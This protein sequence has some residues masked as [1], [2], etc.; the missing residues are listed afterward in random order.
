MFKYIFALASFVAAAGAMPDACLAPEPELPDTVVDIAVSD[1]DFSLLVQALTE[2]ELVDDL[3]GDGPFTVF[4][5]T[6]AAFAALLADLGITAEELLARDDLADILLY[7][8][9]PGEVDSAAAIAA[10]GT[11][12]GTLNG[13]TVDVSL[14]NGDLFI[15]QAQVINT[16]LKAKN[17][18]VHVIDAVLLPD[19]P[20]PATVVDV[21]LQ[22]PD[23]SI[24]YAALV[25]T[26]LDQTLRQSGPYTLFAPTNAAFNDA[27]VALGI[28]LGDLLTDP[29]LADILLYHVL[30]GEVDSSAA[31]AA[32]GTQV[33]T[34]NGD[35]VDVSLSNGNLFIDSAQVID[36]DLQAQNGVVHVIDGVLLPNT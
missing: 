6:N 2:A 17:G 11:Q 10:A 23:F 16:D 18:I 32:A 21:L 20:L 15:D 27:L 25:G 30:A 28:D 24:L 34:V 13:D 9:V 35:T 3:Q 1:P 36:A 19:A 33:P 4:A 26:G 29:N 31:I 8:V 5:P 12:V 22:D 7:H 14:D